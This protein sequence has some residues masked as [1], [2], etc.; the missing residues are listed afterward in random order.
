MDGFTRYMLTRAFADLMLFLFLW[1]PL[2]ELGLL[3]LLTLNHLPPQRRRG[4]F[5][6]FFSLLGLAGVLFGGAWMLEAHGL[7][8]R[9]WFQGGLSLILWLTGLTTGIMTVIYAGRWLSERGKGV[10]TVV[11]ALSALCFVSAMAVGTVLGGLWCLGP[12]EQV[13]TYEG[14]RMVLG[15]WTW[16][17]TSYELYEYHGPLVRGAGPAVDDFRLI[18]V[19]GAVIDW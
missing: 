14:R 19:E 18:D 1:G 3:C 17:D 15:K 11:T 9:T 8:W 4:L 13:V 10:K 12:G 16:M 7:T 2:M 6:L 5:A